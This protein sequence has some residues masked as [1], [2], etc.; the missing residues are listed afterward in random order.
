MLAQVTSL[1]SLSSI[2]IQTSHKRRFETYSRRPYR[3][4]GIWTP[5]APVNSDIKYVPLSIEDPNPALPRVPVPVCVLI[6]HRGIWTRRH[7][8]H[9]TAAKSL[10]SIEE[11]ELFVD[12][13][14]FI[15]ICSPYRPW[16][17]NLADF[18]RS[19][20]VQVLIV[21]RGIWTQHQYLFSPGLERPYRP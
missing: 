18:F 13:V 5:I 1:W 10:S 20:G 12:M 17:T 15:H 9:L 11:S 7:P 16:G 4:W 21:H 8:L 2:D 19:P 6:V 14:Q 3:P